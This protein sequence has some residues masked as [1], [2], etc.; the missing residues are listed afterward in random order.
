M[1]SEVIE[2]EGKYPLSISQL[3]QTMTIK[4]EYND[5]DAL[6]L[7]TLTHDITVIIQLNVG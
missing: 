4:T 3:V 6:E 2:I 7:V 5:Y 1:S